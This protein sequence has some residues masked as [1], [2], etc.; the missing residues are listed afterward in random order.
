MEEW[1][2]IG[3]L[4]SAALFI[5][6]LKKLGHPRTAPLGNQYGALGML[7]AVITTVVKI[8]AGGD[9]QW[10]LIIAGL[11]VGSVIGII[12]AIRVEM[13]GMPELVALFNGFGGAAS[14]LV[15]LS[16]SWKYIEDADLVLPT[17][18]NIQVIMVAAGLSALV[19]WMTLTGS[20]L[21]MFKLKGGISVFGKWMKTPTWGPTWL[22]PVKVLLVLS[23]FALIYLSIGDPRNTDYLWAIIA[24]S[25]ILGIVLVLPIGGADMP[26]V[27]SLLN[28][29][30]GIAAA[31]TGFIIG[32]SV[33]IV[34]GSLVGAS[35]LILTFIMCK[36]MNRTLPDVLFKSFGGS[37]EKAQ[38][39]RTKVGSDADEVAMMVDGAQ[40]VIIVPGYG[41]AVSQ[42]QHQVKEFADLITEK[43]GTEVKYAIHPVAGRMPGHMNVLL[44]E[45]NVPYEQLI[46]MD[47][48]NPEFPDC[49]VAVIIGANDT[50]NPA[51]RSGEGPLAGMPIIDADA[52]RT[53]VIIK[54]SLSVGYA[55]VD[56]DLFYM[57]KTMMLFGDGKAMMTGLNNAIKDI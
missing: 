15:A 46:E 50:T 53:V 6:G 12:M 49:D 47:E 17:G 36:A 1:I 31:F 24:I 51:A 33:L 52:A 48:I 19:G 2:P 37:G 10:T 5:F 29:L 42:C 44:A 7:V 21:A 25:C 14:A 30:S 39:T 45:A 9:A 18:L 40:K 13:T 16:E 32:N 34:A 3:Y 20:I 43:F 55:G 28:S 27:V 56:N 41:M 38:L 54:R 35:G 26:V 23:V 11:V 57:D 22:N 8:Q 4:L